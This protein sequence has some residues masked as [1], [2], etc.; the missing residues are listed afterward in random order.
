MWGVWVQAPSKTRRMGIILEN[1][2]PC[3]WKKDCDSA[4]MRSVS[5]VVD[6]GR[7]DMRL[8]V[9]DGHVQQNNGDAAKGNAFDAPRRQS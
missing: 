5:R 1:W 4:L 7:F 8:V 9:G 3:F 6:G 2:K